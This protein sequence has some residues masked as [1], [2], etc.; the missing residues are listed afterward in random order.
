[1]KDK[2]NPERIIAPSALLR[3]VVAGASAGGGQALAAILSL[4]PED[5]GLPILVAQHLHP[6]D[7][8]GFAE[9]LG[10][11]TELRVVTPCDKHPIAPGTVYVAPANYHL[12]VERQ[13]TLAL[14][15]EGPIN[16]SRPSIDVLFESAANAWGRQV[17][18]ILLT[19][20]SRDG[21][22]GLR[23]VRAL[24]G[25]TVVQDP[26][27]AQYPVMPQSAI[28]AGVADQVLPLEAIGQLL[29]EVGR[30]RPEILTAS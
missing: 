17:L 2:P 8:G 20:A 1:M 4:L 28:D 22:Q 5:Y 29:A 6:D 23:I 24:G 10:M 12:L 9:H 27:T 30:A 3:A 21:T 7:D 25:A 19:G 16:W 15:T 26:A 13:G 18:A 11:Q 14:S